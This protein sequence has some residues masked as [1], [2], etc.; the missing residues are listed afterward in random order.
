MTAFLKRLKRHREGP[1]DHHPRQPGPGREPQ[2]FQK[3][4]LWLAE[5]V[6]GRQ[7]DDLLWLFYG[8]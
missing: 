5:V 8:V 3:C 6:C 2:H 4:H 7:G 1:I